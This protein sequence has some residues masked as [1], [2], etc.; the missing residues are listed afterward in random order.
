MTEEMDQILSFIHLSCMI[1]G[2]ISQL[3]NVDLKAFKP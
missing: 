1:S 3:S 2:I